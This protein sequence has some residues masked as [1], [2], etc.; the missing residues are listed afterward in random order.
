MWNWLVENVF[1]DF[2]RDLGEFGW[3]F[4]LVVIIWYRTWA[5]KDFMRTVKQELV[6][7]RDELKE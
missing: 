2:V 5:L 7:I 1:R 6:A 4:M 3:L